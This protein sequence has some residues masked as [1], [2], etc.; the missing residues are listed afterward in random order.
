LRFG[1]TFLLI[2]L[3]LFG[4]YQPSG[5]SNL[6]DSSKSRKI[7]LV[8][9]I[10]VRNKGSRA[11]SGIAVY[12]PEIKDHPPCQTASI[13]S[14]SPSAHSSEVS[15]S[16]GSMLKFA[17]D[18]IE[19]GE[20]KTFL[21][22]A[23]VTIA[24]VTYNVTEEET[25]EPDSSLKP[26]LALDDSFGTKSPSLRKKCLEF[27]G[28]KNPLKRALKL[29]EYI[30]SGAFTFSN[31]P[32]GVGADRAFEKKHLNCSDAASMYLAMCR[33]SGIPARYVGGIFYTS[34]RKWYPLLHAWAEIYVAPFGWL[35]VDPTLGRLSEKNRGLCFAHMRNRYI[36]L[37]N[38]ELS[39]FYVEASSEKDSENLEVHNSIFVESY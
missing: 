32:V 11:L 25:G 2:L 9:G 33:L 26:Y 5:A 16:G 13:R 7:R 38:N 39:A 3:T 19:A 22:S 23:D 24:E 6:Q 35:P 17:V 18:R 4:D 37:W 36:Q 20:K 12:I 1:I 28:E 8:Y 34:K 14:I 29:Y 30:I 15:P 10:A 31:S 21:V 27:Q